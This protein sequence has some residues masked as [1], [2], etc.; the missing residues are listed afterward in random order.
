M[1]IGT[2]HCYGNELWGGMH[3]H[4]EKF[5]RCFLFLSSFIFQDDVEIYPF[6]DY[7][8]NSDFQTFNSK[9]NQTIIFGTEK[10][11]LYK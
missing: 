3:I 6:I 2:P 8:A 10:S 4:V 5:V 1:Y 7:L 9:P 11:I